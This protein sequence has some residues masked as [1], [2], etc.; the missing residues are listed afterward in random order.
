MTLNAL[1]FLFDSMQNYTSVGFLKT[2][3]PAKVIDLATKFWEQNSFNHT[4]NLFQLILF[5]KK[6]PRTIPIVQLFKPLQLKLQLLVC[7]TINF[8]QQLIAINF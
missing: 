6:W 3:A 7:Y 5:W 8:D 1:F 4:C 2:R